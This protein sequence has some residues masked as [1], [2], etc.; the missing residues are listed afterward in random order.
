M[1]ESLIVALTVEVCV[2][3]VVQVCRYFE[4]LMKQLLAFE[5]LGVCLVFLSFMSLR[6]SRGVVVLP[7]SPSLWLLSEPHLIISFS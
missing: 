1:I 7:A 6:L 2:T 5:V 4:F 3:F